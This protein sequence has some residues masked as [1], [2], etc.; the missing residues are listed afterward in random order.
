MCNVYLGSVVVSM[1]DSHSHD[2]G[3][4]PGPGKHIY[5]YINNFITNICTK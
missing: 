3:S 4:S 5:K 1:M 2:R